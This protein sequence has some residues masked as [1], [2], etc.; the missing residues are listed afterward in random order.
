MTISNNEQKLNVDFG[1][2]P[3][4]TGVIQGTIFNDEGKDGVFQSSESGLPNVTVKLYRD[5]NGNGTLETGTD[6]LVSTQASGVGGAYSFSNLTLT[7]DYLV[8]VDQADADIATGLGGTPFSITTAD[9]HRVEDLVGTYSKAHFGFWRQIPGSISG[10][11]FLDANVDGVMNVGETPIANFAV[12][13]YADA[14]G[15]NSPDPD[16]LVATQRTNTAGAFAFTSLG[17]GDYLVQCDPASPEV[18]PGYTINSDLLSVTIAAGE[19]STGNDF[20]FSR[21][22]TKAVNRTSAVA[23]DQ[24]TYTITPT[25]PGCD[26]LGG[27]TITDSVP[28]GSTFVSAGQGGTHSNGT[29]TWNLGTTSAALPGTVVTWLRVAT[30]PL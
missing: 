6:A 22:L 17:A 29:V 10:K 2:R 4:G 21:L 26:F 11:A 16:E 18:P 1:Y 5:T 30:L 14:D 13:L 25:Y 3:G 8:D 9:P 27:L 15:D 19:N 7:L 24:I 23:G 20:A 12:S 28:T